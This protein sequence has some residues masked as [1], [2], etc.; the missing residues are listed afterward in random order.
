M[1]ENLL[2]EGGQLDVIDTFKGTPEEWGMRKVEKRLLCN[3]SGLIETFKHNISF[4]SHIDFNIMEGSSQALLPKLCDQ[5][6]EFYDFIYIDASHRSADTF[7]DAY[8]AHQLLKPG[9]ILVFDDYEWGSEEGQRRP[10]LAPN[11]TPQLGIDLFYRLH[12]EAYSLIW[13]GYQ[14]YLSKNN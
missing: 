8:Y 14:V 2:R 10:D 5:T 3:P 4:F 12:Q 11:D 1:C 13:Q 9:G 7:V 6:R